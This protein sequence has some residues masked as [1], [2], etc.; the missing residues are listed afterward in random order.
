MTKLVSRNMTILTKKTQALSTAA[1]GQTAIKVRIYQGERELVRDNK[2]LG[3]PP[4][5]KGIPRIDV[6]FDIDAGTFS[7]SA[8]P[9]S[10]DTHSV[11]RLYHLSRCQGQGDQQGLVHNNRILSGLSDKDIEC[12]V[13]EAEQ[14]AETDKAHKGLIGRRTRRTPCAR[15]RRRR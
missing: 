6:T 11:H 4:A 7:C 1:D 12:M 10:A 14:Y 8:F 15:A 2:L 9:S 5:S 3:I 13:S